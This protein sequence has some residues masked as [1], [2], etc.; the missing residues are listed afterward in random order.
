MGK[1]CNTHAKEERNKHLFK[2]PQEEITN[3]LVVIGK[4]PILKNRACGL[5][6]P[7]AG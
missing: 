4:Q 7:G 6:S 3:S 5:D 1:A 2:Y